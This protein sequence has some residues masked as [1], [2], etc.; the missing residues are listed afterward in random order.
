MTNPPPD[1]IV[2]VKRGGNPNARL[3]R[4]KYASARKAFRDSVTTDDLIQI[5]ERM[6]NIAIGV[7]P[8]TALSY[9]PSDSIRAAEFI[10][11]YLVP[12]GPLAE[13]TGS[14]QPPIQINIELYKQKFVADLTGQ[15]SSR[16]SGEDG[17]IEPVHS[18]DADNAA[19]EVP[20]LADR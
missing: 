5:V 20:R 7:D 4:K 19:G 2:L 11:G 15:T 8:E 17:S 1:A 3:A 13:E 9:E 12:K 18:S 14:K 10:F 6:K 16:L